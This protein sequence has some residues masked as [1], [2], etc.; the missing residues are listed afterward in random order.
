MHIYIIGTCPP[1]LTWGWPLNW[2]GKGEDRG[3]YSP[4]Q[5]ETNCLIKLPVFA[6]KLK[7]IQIR[8]ASA[9]RSAAYSQTS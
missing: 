8:Q 5:L 2:T 7:I 9:L 1:N 3:C 6:T 4:G